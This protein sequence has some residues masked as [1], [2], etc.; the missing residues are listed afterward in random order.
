MKSEGWKYYL[1]GAILV[2]LFAAGVVLV[3]PMNWL[4]AGQYKLTGVLTIDETEY[5]FLGENALVINNLR[6]IIGQATAIDRIVY[7]DKNGADVT[8]DQLGFLNGNLATDD[9]KIISLKN[10]GVKIADKKLTGSFAS[11]MG[12]I[13]FQGQTDWKPYDLAEIQLANNQKIEVNKKTKLEANI[14]ALGGKKLYDVDS[15]WVSQSDNV[16]VDEYGY[17]TVTKP[18]DYKNVIL[19]SVAGRE[20]AISLQAVE[21]IKLR[22]D[23][24]K[25]PVEPNLVT[26]SGTKSIIVYIQPVDRVGD[27]TGFQFVR[28]NDKINCSGFTAG[29]G[30]SIKASSCVLDGKGAGDWNLELNTKDGDYVFLSELRVVNPDDALNIKMRTDILKENPVGSGTYIN[31]VSTGNTESATTLYDVCNRVKYTF[32]VEEPSYLNEKQITSGKIKMTFKIDGKAPCKAKASS[33]SLVGAYY[34]DTT[35]TLTKDLV[36]TNGKILDQDLTLNFTSTFYQGCDLVAD[37]VLE[38]LDYGGLALNANSSV[39]VGIGYPKQVELAGDVVVEG[40]NIDIES[41]SQDAKSY[42]MVAQDSI[43]LLPNNQNQLTGYQISD[44]IN[45]AEIIS[46]L[47]ENINKLII[48]RGRLDIQATNI[49]SE[50]SK[51][52]LDDKAKFPEGRII[53][54]GNGVGDYILEYKGGNPLEVCGPVT[55]VVEGR[56]VI[57]KDDI[58]MANVTSGVGG[59][60]QKGNFGLIVLDGDIYFD[61][62]VERVDGYYFTTGT[63]YT[64]E[65]NKQFVLTGVAVA[66]NFVLQRF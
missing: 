23:L 63:M 26:Q 30:G 25:P 50:I 58:V 44:K 45:F 41:T 20:E 60:A 40:G 8:V 12:L 9:G 19:L 54:D 59:C 24:V 3:R 11:D 32:G 36:I 61:G 16:L 6:Q 51:F 39:R 33:F 49:G 65:S 5:S 62:D 34:N 66:N 1:L 27:V 18:G 37:V 28:G 22:V 14:L 42:S 31:C 2:V 38:N 57:V 15:S 52:T 53:Y 46:K 56:D 17:V 4:E 21:T 64:G 48:E 43:K 7:F 35:K 29:T 55:L 10:K 13:N 47:K